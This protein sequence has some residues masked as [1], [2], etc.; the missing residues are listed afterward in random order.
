M[1]PESIVRRVYSK[2]SDIWS[3]G[4]VLFDAWTFGMIPYHL[5]ADD[6]EV[7]RVVLQGERLSRPDNCPQRLYTDM[8][9]LLEELF[10]G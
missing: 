2:K 6:N 3:F 7:A 1:A 9:D 5:I 10:K 8:Q 4:V